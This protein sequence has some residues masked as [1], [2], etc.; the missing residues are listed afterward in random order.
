MPCT[1]P[2]STKGAAKTLGNTWSATKAAW[3]S[4][5][6]ALGTSVITA[7]AVVPILRVASRKHMEAAEARAAEELER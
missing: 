2:C 1:N 5:L 7:V 4:A 6:I 3:V